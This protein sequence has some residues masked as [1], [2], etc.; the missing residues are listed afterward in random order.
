MGHKRINCLLL[1]FGAYVNNTL[2]NGFSVS[3]KNLDR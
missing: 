1:C 2:N 3:R